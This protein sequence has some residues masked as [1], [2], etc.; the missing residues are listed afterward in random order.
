MGKI[1]KLETEARKIFKK[2]FSLG[3]KT[4]TP[5]ILA[6]YIINV[7]EK[8]LL[9]IKGIKV[10]IAPSQYFVLFSHQDYRKLKDKIPEL[11]EETKKIVEEH[12]SLRNYVIF[13]E[14][15]LQFTSSV[16]V[17]S[18]GIEISPEK[19]K[20]PEGVWIVEHTSSDRYFL[21]PPGKKITIG[22]EKNND[23][24]VVNEYI[25]STHAEIEN[26]D[27]SKVILTDLGS[28]NGT[29]YK[30]QKIKTTTFESSDEFSL[31]KQHPE[32]FKVIKLSEQEK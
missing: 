15:E 26:K 4:F 22:R 27:G 23:F 10:K 29:Y 17:S 31:T 11:F 18:G 13:G 5:E 24:I 14:L 25:S 16:K 30:G 21:L 19:V 8:S 28:T 7:I 9:S 6:D 12:I 3:K 20:I 2:I 32:K 1:T